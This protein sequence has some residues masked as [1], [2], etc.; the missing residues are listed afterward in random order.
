MNRFFQCQFDSFLPFLGNLF[1]LLRIRVEELLLDSMGNWS[2][3]SPRKGLNGKFF[4]GVLR[5]DEGCLAR[6]P[7]RQF[8]HAHHKQQKMNTKAMA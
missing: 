2:L 8:H 1:P 4:A 6:N 5:I 7:R 3:R